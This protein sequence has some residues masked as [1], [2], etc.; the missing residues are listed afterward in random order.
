MEYERLSR[1]LE[2]LG[3]KVK[4]F[5]IGAISIDDFMPVED[6][7]RK[8]R[9]TLKEMDARSL[10]LKAAIR[11]SRVRQVAERDINETLE[12]LNEETSNYIINEKTINLCL[13][14]DAIE[15]MIYGGQ[16]NPENQEKLYVIPTKLY[17]LTDEGLSLQKEIKELMQ[18]Q[19]FLKIEAQN[20]AQEY[21]DFLQQQEE[22]RIENLQK[23]N[24]VMAQ[25]K[26]K[27]E[28]TIRK[29]NVMKKLI[30]NFIASSGILLREKPILLEMLEKHRDIVSLETISNMVEN[31]ESS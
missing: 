20:R 17:S 12:K 18:K 9:T 29:I 14:A 15:N 4:E 27:M 6:K 13:E 7:I 31:S 23:S 26:K 10:S 2:M 21:R 1:A 5:P 22:L 16:I 19:L 30:I 11:K 3:R 24:P 8:L 25:Y 28:R